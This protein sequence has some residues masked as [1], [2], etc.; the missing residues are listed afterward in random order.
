MAGWPTPLDNT[1]GQQR[2]N[3]VLRS[4]LLFCKQARLGDGGF[5]GEMQRKNRTDCSSERRVSTVVLK[6]FESWAREDCTEEEEDRQTAISIGPL[7]A[8]G[9]VGVGEGLPSPGCARRESVREW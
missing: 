7:R 1:Q 3:S 9:W 4:L 8:M 5:L 6:R 2:C